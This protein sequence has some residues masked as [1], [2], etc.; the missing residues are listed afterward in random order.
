MRIRS[1]KL[2]YCQ[3]G[4][5]NY[6][7]KI[8]INSESPWVRTIS[9][10]F[11][12]RDGTTNPC[13][14]YADVQSSICCKVALESSSQIHCFQWRCQWNCNF[15]AD[16]IYA[17]ERSKFPSTTPLPSQSPRKERSIRYNTKKQMYKK[18]VIA[19]SLSYFCWKFENVVSS[20]AW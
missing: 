7:N 12:E 14:V 8:H 9:S 17:Y 1:S 4:A 20:K 2:T 10:V 3:A 18:M 6:C 11:V 13:T 16:M 5:V 19:N 15:A